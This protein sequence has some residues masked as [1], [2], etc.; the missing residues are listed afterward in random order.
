MGHKVIETSEVTILTRWERVQN[1][2]LWGDITI[3]IFRFFKKIKEFYK[4]EK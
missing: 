2:T 1:D 4:L 3:L